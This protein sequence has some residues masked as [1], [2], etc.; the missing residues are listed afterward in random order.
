MAMHAPLRRPMTLTLGAAASALALVAAASPAGAA[1]P[2]YVALG[3]SY[4]SGT[5]TRTYISDGTSC[6]RS[7]YAYPSLI[8][9]AK[10]YA[11]TFR[12]CSGAKVPYVTNTQLSA[13]SASTS[14]V[15]MSV[16]GNDAGF[17][18]VLTECAKPGWLSNCNGRIDTA[19]AYIRNTL[20][21]ALSTLYGSIRAKAP[22]ARVTIVGYPRIFN[23]EDCNALTWFS[24]QEE[25]RLNQTAD[26]LNALLAGQASAKG[27]AFANPTSAFIG[28][29]VCDSPEWLNGL[30]NPVSESYHPNRTGHASGY[31]PVVSPSLTGATVSASAAL[32]ASAATSTD[33]LTA[34][35]KRFAAADR[36]IRPEVVRAPDLTS[37]VARAA[38][39]RA[40][41]D[42]TSRASID[43]ADRLWSA[44]E[45]ARWLAAHGG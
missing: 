37:A 18:D 40:G 22:N 12:A 35:A 2:S 13:L 23:G 1:A 11:L 16:G 31:T 34:G 43:A 44:R 42:L 27:F 3:D 45:A 4:S 8:A 30:S 26:Q 14:Y 29:A 36:S 24:P 32:L 20:P 17:A 6:Q 5:G 10:G 7:V 19:Q 33:R 28:H 25:S 41:V 38:A 21:G 39:A 15:S 9:T